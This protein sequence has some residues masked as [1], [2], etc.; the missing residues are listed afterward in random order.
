MAAFTKTQKLKAQ[1]KA[2]TVSNFIS[3][4]R[5]QI[6]P[7]KLD[8]GLSK[9]GRLAKTDARPA[10]H[11]QYWYRAWEKVGKVIGRTMNKLSPLK[12]VVKSKRK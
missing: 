11:N 10:S 3:G 9:V 6:P 7:S 5:F 2:D 12:R 4:M 1:Q 8:K